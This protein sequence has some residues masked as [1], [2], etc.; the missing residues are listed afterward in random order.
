MSRCAPPLTGRQGK[1]V[2][3]D[4]EFR[5]SSY[6]ATV[7]ERTASSLRNALPACRH[8]DG[9][10]SSSRARD[11]RRMASEDSDQ[12]SPGF[13]AIHRLSDLR[14]LDEPFRA[15][16]TT[17]V[18]HLDA[19]RELL[20]VQLLRGVHPVPP[21]ERNDPL[22]QVSSFAHDVAIQVFA[23]VV[24]P[25]IRHDLPHPEE[26]SQLVEARHALR[27]LRNREL[28][29][30]LVAGP[31]AASTAPTRLSDEADREASFSVYK[32]NNPAGPDQPFLLVFCT[33]RIVTA[34]ANKSRASTGRILRFS[35]I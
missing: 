1:C 30:H 19:A 16:V 33:D 27:A 34:H 20:E 4:K 24:V 22:E 17:A 29:S 6:P 12:L 10:I 13:L 32:T 9:T 18:D 25:A 31:V 5:L 11:V 26:L 7:A 28:V 15:Q 8:A 14:D 35:S 3:P 21:E 2:L 23:V